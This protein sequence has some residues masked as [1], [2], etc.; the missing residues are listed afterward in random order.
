MLKSKISIF[1]FLLLL[2]CFTAC[3]S[4]DQSTI[5]KEKKLNS[6]LDEISS[7]VDLSSDEAAQIAEYIVALFQDSKGIL[8]IGTMSKGVARYD[9]SLPKGVGQGKSLI[10]V[11]TEDGLANN[12]VVSIEEDKEGNLW[13]G[14]HSGLSKYNGKTFTNFNKKNGLKLDHISNL[15]IDKTGN[16]WIGAWGGVTHF[17]GTTFTDFPLP[18]PDI[19]IPTY[20]ETENWVTEIIEDSQ[21]NIWIGRSGY[22][23]CKYDGTSFKHFT[24]KD[25]LA[26]NC[27]QDIEE[28]NEGN[29]WFTSRVAEKDHPDVDKRSGDGG[30]SKYTPT[31]NQTNNNTFTQ[32]PELKGLNKND[33]YNIY[34]DKKGNL[35]IGANN[36]GLYQYD[37]KEFKLFNK[38]DRPDLNNNFRGI[39]SLL[40]DKNGNLWIGCSGGL[41][42]LSGT[43]I[44]NVTQDGPWK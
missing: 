29:I 18:N 39:Q 1:P 22:G 21:G 15:L 4:Q 33:I 38:I 35:W 24:K 37:G 26:S 14:T 7:I 40:E 5:S 12:T 9:A 13:F 6:P 34:K 30:L 28:D 27:I 25:G 41:Y 10:Y 43:S 20:Q 36:T 16:I 19:E 32:F 23:A 8:W 11:T 17:D 42:R 3:S 44:I 2:L 31:T